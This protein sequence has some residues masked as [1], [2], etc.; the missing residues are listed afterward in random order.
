MSVARCL[1]LGGSGFMG[2]HLVELLVEQGLAVRVFS[3][4][5]ASSSSLASV[6][7]R[8][9]LIPGD[10][11]DAKAL[12]GAVRGCDYVY[13]FIATTTPATSNRD[14]PFDAESNLIPTMR[15][16]EA[17]VAEKVR[18]II[19]SSSGG[20]VYGDTDRT[21]IP[22]THP[23]EPRSSYGIVKLTI[24]KYLALFHRLHGL[25]YAV[26]RVG[27]CYG[28][29]LPIAGE[30]GVVGAFLDRLRRREPIVLW[31]DGSVRRDYVYVVDVARAFAAARGQQS[32]LKVFNIGTGVGTSLL[33]LIE[34]MERLTG[35]RANIL[36]KPAR[37]VDVPVN[38]LDSARA[39]RYLQWT[40]S[41][42]LDTGLVNTWDW[43]QAAEMR[44]RPAS[45]Q[46]GT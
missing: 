13:H 45:V 1:V 24:E 46:P 3:V 29:R 16:L 5:A 21:P 12:A 31:G 6:A 18:Q 8:V 43:I 10:F 9:E 2:S 37:A 26:L 41:T 11:R 39:S 33:E 28:P 35:C 7:Q 42:P 25:D 36:K 40:P 34:R 23:T 30:Q 15:L 19:F 17:C 38:I 4:S 14:V 20:A 22:E 27:N 44:G 32:P